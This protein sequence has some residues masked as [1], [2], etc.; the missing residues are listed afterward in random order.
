MVIAKNVL[1][2]TLEICCTSPMTGFYRNGACE[3]GSRD[4]GTHVVCAEVTEEFFEFTR[5]RGN[6]LI[7]PSPTHG[8]LGLKPGD[9]WCLCVSRWREAL[10][11]GV[12]PTCG[13]ISN[14]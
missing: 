12:A 10:D 14:A 7:T 13:S 4:I 3:T 11:G 2:E 5:S 9:N 6:N 1:G 8:F